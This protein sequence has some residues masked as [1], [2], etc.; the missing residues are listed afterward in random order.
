MN[1]TLALLMLPLGLGI[2]VAQSVPLKI[3]YQGQLT[4]ASGKP[5]PDKDRNLVFRILDSPTGGTLLWENTFAEVPVVGG[6]FNVALDPPSGVF[7]GPA[8]YLEVQVIGGER[9]TPRQQILS[10]PFAIVADRARIAER[11]GGGILNTADNGLHIQSA[12]SYVRLE[13]TGGTVGNWYVWAHPDNGSLTFYDGLGKSTRMV[14]GA[15]GGVGIGTSSPE[16]SLHVTGV[17]RV[18]GNS[19]PTGAGDGLQLGG[20]AEGYQWIQS[21]ND[22][23]LA[24]NPLGNAVGIG[25]NQ[26]T[27]TLHVN[28]SAGKPGGGSWSVAS[29]ARLKKNVEPLAGALERLLQLQGKTF[30]FR[31]PE[32]IGE[33]RGRQTGMI[34]Q[35]VEEVFPEWVDEGPDGYRRVIYRGF[36]ALTVEALR[37]LRAEK[38]VRI[39][40]LEERNR[41]LE[42]RLAAL[43]RAVATLAG[44]QAGAA[45]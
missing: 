36:E 45:K 7:S 44:Q 19:A 28:G 43:E 21:Y 24:L 8:R 27:F 5:L 20:L 3:N 14:I 12:G 30:E 11:I 9:I 41:R 13:T 35:E 33:L 18:K 42:E 39:A 34:A 10:A 25:I 31:D 22:R 38:Q 2:A 40:E 1:K 23:P 6:H 15:N 17:V 32:K 4:D 29:D 16:E 37:D 26:P